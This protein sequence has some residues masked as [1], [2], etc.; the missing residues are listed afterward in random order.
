M[1]SCRICSQLADVETAFNKNGK[2]EY[3]SSLPLAF[4]ELTRIEEDYHSV[5][6]YIAQCPLCKTKYHYRS[7]YEFLVGGSEDEITLTR[8]LK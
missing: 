7:T 5:D 1:D 3:S 6:D 8:L 2:P 4:N